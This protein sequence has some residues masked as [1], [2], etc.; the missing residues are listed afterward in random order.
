[1][2]VENLPDVMES[3]YTHTTAAS[4]QTL[5]RPSGLIRKPDGPVDLAL[6]VH[7]SLCLRQINHAVKLRK[8][9]KL[10]FDDPLIVGFVSG[11]VFQQTNSAGRVMSS[12]SKDW[13]DG[14]VTAELDSDDLRAAAKKLAEMFDNHPSRSTLNQDD[15]NYMSWVL[16]SRMFGY[17]SDIAQLDDVMQH[18]E[19]SD[20]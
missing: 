5:L 16:G 3:L 7:A 6:S 8:T 19:V 20:E 13:K 15:L 12:W 2:K 1:M 18:L 11:Y 17:I 10:E 14:A 4:S 9:L